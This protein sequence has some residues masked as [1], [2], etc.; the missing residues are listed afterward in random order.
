VAQISDYRPHIP[1]LPADYKLR[2]IRQ[3]HRKY[4]RVYNGLE[5]RVGDVEIANSPEDVGAR[6]TKLLDT[7]LAGVKATEAARQRTREKSAEW[8]R[9]ARERRAIALDK[10]NY[11][12]GIKAEAEANHDARIIV[13]I[14]GVLTLTVDTANDDL[15]L[16][17]SNDL[18]MS[19][20]NFYETMRTL[21]RGQ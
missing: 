5:V 20:V 9:L 17:A 12:D 6:A 2:I 8:A 14:K 4:L 11:M 7:H 21:G 3:S 16:V 18:N 15:M 1:N 10:L 13:T 19:A